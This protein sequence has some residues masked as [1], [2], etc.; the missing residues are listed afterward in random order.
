MHRPVLGEASLSGI[1]LKR[2]ALDMTR[3]EIGR[4][5]PLLIAELKCLEGS[6]RP[7]VRKDQQAWYDACWLKLMMLTRDIARPFCIESLLVWDERRKLLIRVLALCL[8][9][10]FH[11][12][13]VRNPF[14]NFKES[15]E[16]NLPI[17]KRELLLMKFKYSN[18]MHR[19]TLLGRSTLMCVHLL[20]KYCK[21]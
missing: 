19:E 9:S 21:L 10:S 11:R 4:N 3:S 12:A 2:Q 1:Q 17:L 7:M 13:C 15:G 16:G 20:L 18:C 5:D 14:V 8:S 6:L